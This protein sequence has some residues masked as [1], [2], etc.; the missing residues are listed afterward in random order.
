MVGWRRILIA[1]VAVLLGAGWAGGPATAAEPQIT[2][3]ADDAYRYPDN[4]IGQP[5]EKPPVG[6]LSNPTADILSVTLAKA[7]PLNP[8]HDNGYSVSVAVKGTP[9]ATYNYLVGGYF[10]EDCYLIAFLKAGETRPAMAY[11]GE[12]EATRT[13]ASFEGSAVTV[14]GNTIAASY[15]FRRFTLPSQMKKNSK[16]EDLYAM[17]CPVT[18]KS[19][20][21]SDD[22]I[23]WA[24]SEAAFSI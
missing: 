8:N 4:P 3:A 2:D 15:S 21:C 6:P 19:W 1:F 11:C 9:H 20:G 12:G 5:A 7:A 22:V 17:S 23:D 14:K 10:G 16:V 13:V 18:S 24:F